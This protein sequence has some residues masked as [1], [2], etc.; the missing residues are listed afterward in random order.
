MRGSAFDEETAPAG[1]GRPD[2]GR[3]ECSRS[4]APRPRDAGRRLRTEGARGTG[5]HPARTIEPFALKDA[6]GRTHQPTDWRDATAVV[7][8]VIG[9][10]CPVSGA[11]APEMRR[12]ADR[13]GPKGVLFFGVQ[14]DPSVSGEAVARHAD[15]HGLPFPVLL[16]P[17]HELTG[18]LGVEGTPEAAVLDARRHVRYRGRIDERTAPGGTSPAAPGPRELEGAIVA[19]IEGCQIPIER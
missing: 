2:A 16:D 12:L 18:E 15:E 14:P 13:Y 5:S 19:A 7:L 1:G 9:G 6:Q 3:G 11:Y 17:S 8:F 4:R 10:D